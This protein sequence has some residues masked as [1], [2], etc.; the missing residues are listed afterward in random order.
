MRGDGEGEGR[1]LDAWNI[2][3]MHINEIKVVVPLAI[4]LAWCKSVHW[5]FSL[6]I[7]HKG[8]SPRVAKVNTSFENRERSVPFDTW[9]YIG[10]HCPRDEIIKNFLRT[11]VLNIF[12]EQL[13]ASAHFKKFN[14]IPNKDKKTHHLFWVVLTCT[15]SLTK[16]LT[17]NRHSNFSIQIFKCTWF[18]HVSTL[19]EL[20]CYENHLLCSSQESL[21][22][23]LCFERLSSP[24]G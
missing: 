14:F 13:S 12:F 15:N 18:L 8:R 1:R 22:K 17:G 19:F 6:H 3:S 21:L 7:A 16:N 5:A 9:Q 4:E 10:T 11:I 20:N 24:R 23:A 2:V